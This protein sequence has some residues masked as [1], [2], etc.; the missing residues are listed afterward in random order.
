MRK[1]IINDQAANFDL[2][3]AHEL[4]HMLL[5][6]FFNPGVT[7]Q[8]GYGA[9]YQINPITENTPCPFYKVTSNCTEHNNPVNGFDWSNTLFDHLMQANV[10]PYILHS[11]FI[12]QHLNIQDSERHRIVN[13]NSELLTNY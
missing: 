11:D 6:Y 4:G 8:Q 9:S 12:Q 13:Y 7:T 3:L 10:Y 2:T 1:I 5:D